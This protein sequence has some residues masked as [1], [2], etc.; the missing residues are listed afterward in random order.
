MREVMQ[1]WEE[2]KKPFDGMSEGILNL[3]DVLWK[4]WAGNQDRADVDMV[5]HVSEKVLSQNHWG[6]KA[7]LGIA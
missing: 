1:I 7:P 6:W 3:I 4:A 2:F 5:I